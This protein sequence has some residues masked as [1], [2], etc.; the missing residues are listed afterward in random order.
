M[1]NAA[2]LCIDDV[3]QVLQSIA[4][5]KG[6]VLNVYGEEELMDST[7]II[8]YPA[9]GI[10]YEGMRSLEEG[11]AT[12]K[13]GTSSEL[14]ISIILIDTYTKMTKAGSRKN[15]APILDA[16]RETM[17]QV[18]RRSPTGHKWRFIVEA[19]ASPKSGVVLWVQR[20]STP[21]QLVSAPQ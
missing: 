16:I 19:A 21:V 18:K 14:V 10:V 7:S 13:V 3:E 9:C 5:L 12:N 17:M 20:W 8:T 15:A 6:K 11:G 2:T 4:S 1:I